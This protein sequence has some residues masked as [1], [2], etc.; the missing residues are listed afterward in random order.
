MNSQ[1]KISNRS[2]DVSTTTRCIW[3]TLEASEVIELKRIA[4]DRDMDSAISFFYD[5]LTPRVYKAALHRGVG[6]DK[7]V[8]EKN[9]EHISG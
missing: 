9:I 7:L 3:V 4:M 5:L 1:T 8:E 6:L 2:I